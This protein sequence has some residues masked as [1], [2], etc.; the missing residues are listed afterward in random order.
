MLKSLPFTIGWRYTGAKRRN[1]FISFISGISIAGLALGVAVLILVLSVMNGF[2][3]EL[4]ERILGMVPHASVKGGDAIEDWQSLSDTIMNTE[5][6]IGI[7]PFVNIQGM[8]SHRGRVEG[9]MVNGVDPAHEEK[10]SILPNFIKKGSFDSL[11]GGDYQII[12]GDLLAR[13]LG[14]SMG[15]KVTLI[16]PEASLTPA[17]VMPRLKRFT[18]SGIFSVGA[19]LDASFAYIHLEDAAKLARISGKVQG[20]R[21]QTEDLF[22]APQIAWQLAAELPGYYRSDNWTRTHGNLFQAI[23]MEK[24]MI[25]LLLFVIVAVAAFN[26]VSTLVMVVTDKQSDIAILRTLGMSSRSILKVFLV[27]GVIIGVVGVVIGVLLGLLLAMTVTDLV[28]GLE[29]LLGVQFLNANV[30]FIS[31]LPSEIRWMDVLVISMGGL[32]LAFAATIYPAYRAS[33]VQPAEA[34]RYDI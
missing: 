23:K 31:Y 1:H 21:L 26:I 4:R 24:T 15:D 9:V 8:L 29:T 32:L 34:L 33:K 25:G 27:Q 7:A 3:R 22:R 28:A 18:V 20:V 14:A 10:V 30:Y 2:E 11:K 13:Q 19:E 17:G 12:L 16:M 5:G 6:V